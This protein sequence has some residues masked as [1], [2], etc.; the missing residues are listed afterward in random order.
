MIEVNIVDEDVN[1]VPDEIC[2]FSVYVP[3]GRVLPGPEFVIGV[4]TTTKAVEDD[5]SNL[6]VSENVSY[7]VTQMRSAVPYDSASFVLPLN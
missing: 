7:D 4:F 6:W 3:T 5:C 2:M 1:E